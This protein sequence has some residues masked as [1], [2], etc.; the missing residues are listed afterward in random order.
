MRTRA[1]A[2]ATVLLLVVPL[3][4]ASSAQPPRARIALLDSGI[5]ASHPE[6]APGQVVAWRDFVNVSNPSPTPYDDLGHGTATASR[7]AGLTLGADPGAPLVIG[8][9][10]SGNDV[11]SW[12]VV[13]VGIDWAVQQGASVI[14]VSIWSP[15]LDL[16]SSRIL[17]SAIER[18][19]S[20]GV[21]VVWI[22]GNG[23]NNPTFFNEPVSTPS[24][25]LA[26]SDSPAALVVGSTDSA[27]RRAYDSRLDPE[28][29]AWGYAVPI[30]KVGGGYHAGFGTSFAAPAVAG[31]LARMVDAGAP[32]DVGWLKW[33]ALHCAT[34]QPGALYP[35]EGYG[36]VDALATQCALDVSAGAR[37]VPG[38]DARDAFH[39]ASSALRTAVS[40]QAPQGATPP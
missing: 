6:F 26:G 39:L 14:S 38:P 1:L 34:P 27:G 11:A 29:V 10:L 16:P 32:A 36:F 13:A 18:A 4:P 19:A 25:T 17:A 9:V 2:L 3:T 12:S 31:L 35:M 20:H 28:V 5:D 33:V 22:A 24:S 23:A 40:E 21:P 15:S 37:P 8:K 30:A 7:A